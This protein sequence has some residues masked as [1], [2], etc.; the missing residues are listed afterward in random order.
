[1]TYLGGIWA[2]LGL[3][4]APAVLPVLRLRSSRAILTRSRLFAIVSVPTAPSSVALACGA[5]AL[6]ARS[7][8]IAHAPALPF[9]HARAVPSSAASACTG[10]SPTALMGGGGRVRCRLPPAHSPAR[11]LALPPA[12]SLSRPSTCLH[13]RLPVHVCPPAHQL[14]RL[15]TG[16][17]RV[18]RPCL[19]A[20][21]SPGALALGV[22]MSPQQLH[23]GAGQLRCF[24]PLGRKTYIPATSL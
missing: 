9:T 2:G 19:C 21:H 18:R 12:R 14:A 10:C 20:G 11:P 1:M 8:R 5:L 13:I 3:L 24:R 16:S 17:T 4:P 7:R 22:R 6:C 15:S 23:P